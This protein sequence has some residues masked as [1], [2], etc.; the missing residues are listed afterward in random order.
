MAP[1]P[2]PVPTS[3]AHVPSNGWWKEFVDVIPDGYL[4]LLAAEE[5]ASRVAHFHPTLIPGLLQTEDY[6]VAVT[7]LT[8]LNRTTAAKAASLVRVRMLRQRAALD[9]SRPKDLVFLMDETTLHR[10]VGPPSV[11]R[12]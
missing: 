5:D 2:G 4:D 10:P 12:K 1:D 3:D 7:P 8:I 11:M 6:A 9:G